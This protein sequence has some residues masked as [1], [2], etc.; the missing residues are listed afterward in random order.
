MRDTVVIYYALFWNG[1]N[2]LQCAYLVND[3]LQRASMNRQFLNIIHEMVQILQQWF[4]GCSR[5]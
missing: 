2:G 1:N 4:I 3:G 5:G